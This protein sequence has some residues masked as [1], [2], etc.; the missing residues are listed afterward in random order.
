MPR[1]VAYCCATLNSV[2]VIPALNEAETIGRV[3][4]S[5]IAFGRPIVVDDG[6]TDATGALAESAGALVV[7]HPSNRGYDA[8]LQ[9]GFEKAEALGADIVVTFDADGQHQPTAVPSLLAI[10]LSG[11]A[12]L[13]IGERP[14]AART[15]EYLFNQ[16]ARWRH[17]VPDILCGLKGYNTA[18]YR[19]HGCFDRYRLIGTELASASLAAG[20]RHRLINVPVSQRSGAPRFG[21]RLRANARILRALAIT[22]WFDLVGWRHARSPSWTD[23]A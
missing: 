15:A 14:A 13:V 19:K 11:E 18:L 9:S 22:V 4:G 3:V 6:S 10:L 16:Y 12:D 17:G 7:R 8:A 5:L 1:A 20:A 23:R 21:R 2:I